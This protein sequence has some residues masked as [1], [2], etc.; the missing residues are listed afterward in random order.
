ML[1]KKY[2]TNSLVLQIKEGFYSARMIPFLLLIVVTLFILYPLVMIVI[3]SFTQDGVFDIKGY[4]RVFSAS[5]TYKALFNTLIMIFG[6]LCGTWFIGGALAFIRHKTDFIHKRRLDKLVFLSFSIPSYILAIAWV[7]F[8]SRG[9]YLDQILTW[10]LP[11]VHY[12]IDA[13]N[14][15]ACIV[16]LSLHLYPLVYYGVGNAIKLLDSSMEHS[17]KI[18]GAGKKEIIFKVIVPLVLP[19]F[20]STGL[21]VISRSMANFGVPAQ[22]IQPRGTEVL[23]TKIYAAMA[24]LD[25]A[26]VSVLSL[27]LVAI[28]L[29]LFYVSEKC[30]K[31]RAYSTDIAGSSTGNF[32]IQLGN[33]QKYINIAITL[34]YACAVIIPF[35][36]IGISSFFKRW[37]LPFSLENMTLNNYRMLFFADNLL[38][39]PLVNSLLFGIVA[40]FIASILASFSVYFFRYRPSVLS[41]ALL[42]ISQLPIAVPNIVL[43]I[44]AM[45][46]WINEPFKLYGTASIIVITYAVLFTP[47]CIKQILGVSKNLN[48]HLDA[49][50]STLGIPLLKRFTFL[51]LPQIK[52]GFMSAFI[53][54]FMISLKEIPISLLLYSAGTKTLG[55]MLFTIQSNS[56]G[57]E[58][59]ATFSVV[60][61][62][63]SCLGNMLL[64]KITGSNRR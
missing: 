30:I 13:Y 40:A 6:V 50:A 25:L 41:N 55:V 3:T 49:S 42:N 11:F 62:A 51:F 7:L 5:S 10:L 48:P 64:L 63:L 17:A 4:S 33:K 61:I 58:M 19:S 26:M 32:Y 20:L 36:V 31:G 57:L 15:L 2:S 24:Q 27:L 47:I 56:Y 34:Y 23:T 8:I 18:C 59:T 29:L 45:F 9:G 53:L 43:A 1:S 21:L 37:G 60:V 44:A 39:E 16:V 52:N 38:M 28:S 35:C 46:A 22:L 54:C 12:R 14:I